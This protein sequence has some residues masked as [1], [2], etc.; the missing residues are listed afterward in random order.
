MTQLYLPHLQ[1]PPLLTP[2]SHY[3]HDPIGASVGL[4]GAGP[5]AYMTG[6]QLHPPMVDDEEMW[7]TGAW[8]EGA[9]RHVQEAAA[10]CE[11]RPNQ[12]VLD[13]GCGIGGAARVLVRQAGVRVVGT[14]I[15]ATQLD[16]ARK[17]DAAQ[18][19]DRFI[20]YLVHD[21][22]TPLPRGLGLFHLAW[23]MNML[24][25]VPDVHAMLRETSRAL[26][27]GGLLMIDDWMLT[28]RASRRDR[29]SLRRHFISPHFAV[30]DQLAA[31][32]ARHPLRIIRWTDLGSVGRTH[33]ASHFRTVFEERFR[34]VIEQAHGA[35][36][37]DGFVAGVERTIDLYRSEKMTYVRL[38]AE[39]L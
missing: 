37:A 10:L 35:A 36:V 32:L 18:R 3:E 6:D 29:E 2:R 33:L 24:Y 7:R 17:L 14:N 21:C 26:T 30:S 11:L 20:Q 27:P 25:H 23:C 19:L 13:V 39:K 4:A 22:Q 15:A 16:T 1:R 34:A 5:L 12:R 8:Y 28:T 9:V 31:T 38:V